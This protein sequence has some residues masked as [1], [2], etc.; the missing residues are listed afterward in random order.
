V[1]ERAVRVV[2]PA[3]KADPEYVR[4]IELRK[5]ARDLTTRSYKAHKADPSVEY[6][7]YVQAHL[8]FGT[9]PARSPELAGQAPA[10]GM[11]EAFLALA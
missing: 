4:H 3:K 11:H 7:D 6:I 5:L 2:K 9:F 1:P 10:K 8:L